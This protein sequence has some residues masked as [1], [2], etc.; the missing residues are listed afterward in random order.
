MADSSQTRLGI[1]C[2]V[3]ASISF[4]INDASIKFISGAYPLHEVVTF[5][6]G[7]SLIISLAILVPMEGGYRRLRTSKLPLHLLRGLLVVGANSFFFLGLAV[8]PLSDAT[9]LFFIAPV[10]ITIFS[11]VFLGEKVGKF[12][13]S[14][15]AIG[16]IGAVIMLRPT[17]ASFQPVAVL[18]LL[19]AVCYAGIHML[20]R[21]MGGTE[22]ASTL[23]V[24]IQGVFLAVGL[25]MGLTFGDGRSLDFLLRA[26]VVP[27]PADYPVLLI[28]GL[29]S[30]IGGYCVSQAY[31]VSEAAV[32]A[33]FEYTALVMSIVLGFTI[34]GT[35]PDWVAW[36]GTG[37][38]LASGLVVFWREAVLNRRRTSN[39]FRQR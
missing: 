28:I 4:S 38:I 19:A 14:A 30:A 21:R 8:M 35:L 24:Y 26:W 32:I 2:A 36:T 16:L 9:A 13:W 33:P 34:F 37:L 23:S 39:A 29:S 20:S 1:I 18:P 31:R 17:S 7:I 25:V 5:R 27:P 6:A 11:V 22:S 10:V 15:T 12:R 3:I